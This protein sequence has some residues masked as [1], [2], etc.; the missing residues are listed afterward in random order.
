MPP[1]PPKADQNPAS[2][3][4]VFYGQEEALLLNQ[5]FGRKIPIADITSSAQGTCGYKTNG[6]QQD[7]ISR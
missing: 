6:L 5:S 7:A 3:R 2:V 4:F 1:V